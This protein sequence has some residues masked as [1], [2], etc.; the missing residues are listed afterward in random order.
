M[1]GEGYLSVQVSEDTLLPWAVEK[2]ECSFYY[3]FLSYT[4]MKYYV[5]CIS[6]VSLEMFTKSTLGIV[7]P[8]LRIL[9]SV[10]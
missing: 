9:L 4:Y 2:K 10:K 3:Y 5:S 6:Q 8:K 1:N 7:F